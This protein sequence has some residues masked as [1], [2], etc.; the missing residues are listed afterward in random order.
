MRS[1]FAF[2][3]RMLF[4]FVPRV[5]PAGFTALAVQSIQSANPECKVEIVR[6]LELKVAFGAKAD[7]SSIFLENA[8]HLYLQAPWNRRNI[9]DHYS[10]VFASNLMESGEVLLRNVVPVVKDTG[11][12][13]GALKT[14]QAQGKEPNGFFVREPLN[15]SLDIV[16]GV[17]TENSIRYLNQEEFSKL[18]LQGESLRSIAIENLRHLLPE[19]Q[20]KQFKGLFIVSAGGTYEASLLLL[21]SFWNK[22]QFGLKGDFVVG[23]PSR[24]LLLVADSAEAGAVKSLLH[25]C[26]EAAGKSS[27]PL[28]SQLF[29]REAGKFVPLPESAS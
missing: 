6:D 2:A 5:N 28:T 18:H 26:R 17:D 7:S 16:Y 9:I 3:I 22:E 19:I 11:F 1:L 12:V 13:T 29:R 20:M 15:E 25:F 21:E 14:I 27:Y 8:Y 24:E 4:R 10:R 23:I